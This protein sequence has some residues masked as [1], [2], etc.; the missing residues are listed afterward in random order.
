MQAAGLLTCAEDAGGQRSKVGHGC[1]KQRVTKA[2]GSFDSGGG[3]P[4][5]IKTR[6][7]TPGLQSRFALGARSAE[8]NGQKRSN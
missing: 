4:V 5:P 8:N 6:G 2:C 3:C 1:R 7:R